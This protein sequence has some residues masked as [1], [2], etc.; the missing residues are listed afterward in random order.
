[1][2]TLVKVLNNLEAQ[3]FSKAEIDELDNRQ[4]KREF[5]LE[6]Q[7]YGGNLA[8]IKGA[9]KAE[10]IG[11]IINKDNTLT[12]KLAWAVVFTPEGTNTPVADLTKSYLLSKGRYDKN[13]NF[14]APKGDIRQWAD[15]NIIAGILEKEWCNKL[16]TELN[17]RGLCVTNTEYQCGRKDGG[18][19]TATLQNP[20]FADTFGK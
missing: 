10:K 1:M 6:G 20:Y 15:R 7:I 18:S 12:R 9:W 5:F 2:A 4:V 16:A 11:I 3:G 19:F 14:V 13:D 8:T 17:T